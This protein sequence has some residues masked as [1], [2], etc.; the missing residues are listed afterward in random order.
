[1]DDSLIFGN[2]EDRHNVGDITIASFGGE[3]CNVRIIKE[4][5]QKEYLDYMKRT[6]RLVKHTHGPY[7]YAAVGD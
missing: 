5:T 1:M 3:S 2:A 6:G 4:A 7:Y